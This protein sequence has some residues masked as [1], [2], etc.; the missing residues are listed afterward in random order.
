MKKNKFIA[1]IISS[2]MLVGS[3]VTISSC[4]KG[5][6]MVDYA[7][8]GSVKLSLDYADHDFFRDG[9]GEVTIETYIDGDTTHFRNVYGDSTK[10]IKS[11]YYGIDTPESTGAIQPFGKKASA[12]TKSK[13]EKAAANGTIVVSSPFS[14]SEEGGAGVYNIPETDSSGERYLSLVWINENVKHA[15]VDSLILLNLWIVQEGLSWAKN[16]SEVPYY[17]PVFSDAQKQAENLTLNLWSEFDP[18]F[19]Y[20]GY[21]TISLLDLKDEVKKYLKNPSYVNSYT[22]ANVRFTA[23]VGGYSNHNLYLQQYYPADDDDYAKAENPRGEWAGINFFCGMGAIPDEYTQKGALIE[24][25]GKATNS[26]TF[27]FQI[28]DG[29]FMNTDSTTGL[30]DDVCRVLLTAEENDGEYEILPFEYTSA[31]LNALVSAGNYES[32]Y[33]RT[34]VTNELYCNEVRISTGGDITLSFEGCDFNAYIPFTYHGDPNNPSDSWT[35]ADKF[36]GKTFRLSGVFAYNLYKYKDGTFSLRYQIV[37]CGDEDLVCMTDT[38]GTTAGS[39][40]TVSEAIDNFANRLD[41]V[42]YYVYGKVDE[43]FPQ[44]SYQATSSLTRLTVS[45][46]VSRSKGLPEGGETSEKFYITGTVSEITSEYDTNYKSM[47]F[48][49]TDGA[50]TITA[51]NTRFD[52]EHVD[53]GVITVGCEVQIEG[54]IKNYVKDSTATPEITSGKVIGYKNESVVSFTMIDDSSRTIK[55]EQ[56]SV[57]SSV[58]DAIKDQNPAKEDAMRKAAIAEY[59]G[60][61]VVGSTVY[62]KGVPMYINDVITYKQVTFQGVYL[63]GQVENDPLSPAEAIA[64]AEKL[65][66]GEY[67]SNV[68]YIEGYVEEVINVDKSKPAQM[69]ITLIIAQNG[70]NFYVDGAVFKANVTNVSTGEPYTIDDVGEGDKVLIMG[71]LLKDEDETLKTRSNGCQLLNLAKSS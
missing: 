32:L 5:P 43:V 41:K 26:D 63:H 71:R 15:P 45:E 6:S 53:Y 25:V 39:P 46:A 31:Q 68:Y 16:T 52:E 4:N 29:K 10:L 14:T 21:E 7:H 42:T 13:L 37:V 69:R 60:K 20:G 51:Y 58:T 36:L 12:F 57:P 27:G 35:T 34:I 59:L 50:N 56:A 48:A 9:I 23:V 17:A 40:Y 62:I 55:V 33:C 30:E 18:D 2:F 54:K 44:S 28:S 19:N 3:A 38:H 49:M 47:S 66:K 70:S 65:D 8:N 11:R 22:G 1:F 64:I 61:V 67:T 24:V